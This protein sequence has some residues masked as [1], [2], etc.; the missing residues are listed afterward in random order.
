MIEKVDQA[1]EAI[2]TVKPRAGLNI[3]AARRRTF[4]EHPVLACWLVGHQGMPRPRRKYRTRAWTCPRCYTTFLA[5]MACVMDGCVWEWR[6]I[7]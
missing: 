1:L 3:E 2:A 6:E 7:D 4:H 5:K